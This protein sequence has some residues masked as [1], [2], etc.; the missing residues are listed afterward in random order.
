LYTGYLTPFL[1]LVTDGHRRGLSTRAIAELLYA[2]GARADTSPGMH[3]LTEAHHIKNLRVM[4]VYAQ[5]RLGLR[6]RRP[7]ARTQLTA[8]PRR[9][10]GGNVVWEI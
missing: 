5:I 1:P 9:G 4:V 3:R 10:A 6:A 2:A 7:R 8:R